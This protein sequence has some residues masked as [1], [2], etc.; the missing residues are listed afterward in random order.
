MVALEE[1]KTSPPDSFSS[2]IFNSG[3]SRTLIE[4]GP[5]NRLERWR[6]LDQDHST[7][8]LKQLAQV[9]HTSEVVD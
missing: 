4:T 3:T 1:A 7:D 6:I 5:R 2:R 9:K 8:G